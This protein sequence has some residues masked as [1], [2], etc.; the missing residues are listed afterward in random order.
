MLEFIRDRS[1]DQPIKG[2]ATLTPATDSS[3]AGINKN[4]QLLNCMILL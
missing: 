4:Y 2:K 1:R 3:N